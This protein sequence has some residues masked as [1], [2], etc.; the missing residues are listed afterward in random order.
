MLDIVKR[1]QLNVNSNNIQDNVD[2]FLR[3]LQYF[4]NKNMNKNVVKQGL[5]TMT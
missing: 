2:L 5:K 1:Q 4:Q 3:K